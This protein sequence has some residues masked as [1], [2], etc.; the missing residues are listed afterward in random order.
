MSTA[1]LQKQAARTLGNIG[2]ASFGCVSEQRPGSVDES[3][4]RDPEGG[5]DRLSAAAVVN[6]PAIRKRT[7]D[8]QAASTNCRQS[9]RTFDR[10]QL[11]DVADLETKLRRGNDHFQRPAI[12]GVK[13]HIGDQF[14]SYQY[15]PIPKL[16]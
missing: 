8:R 12:G 4:R 16:G 7:H 15:G 1:R 11:A 10:V 2:P 9:G 6:T 13:N 3:V 14:T 5:P